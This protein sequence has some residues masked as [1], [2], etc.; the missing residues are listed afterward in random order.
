MIAIVI[1][2]FS[3]LNYPL[4]GEKYPELITEDSPTQRVSGEVSKQFKSIQH[5]QRMLSLNDV[6]SMDEVIAWQTKLQ[7]ILKLSVNLI[8][9]YLD[10]KM[11]GLA[12]SLIYQDSRLNLG[13]TRGDGLDLKHYQ[14]H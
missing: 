11:D 14:T 10:I 7:G 6:F 4:L 3:K 5:R 8:E 12:C 1:D 2:Y 9:Y 13:V